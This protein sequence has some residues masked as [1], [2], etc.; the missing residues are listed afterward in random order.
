MSAAALLAV[1]EALDVNIV[2]GLILASAVSLGVFALNRG[3]LRMGQT[4]PEL[5]RFPLARRFLQ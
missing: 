4:F 2:E 5:L 3:L 1:Q